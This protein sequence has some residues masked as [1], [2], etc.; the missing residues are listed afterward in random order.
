MSTGLRCPLCG[1]WYAEVQPSV[2][3]FF[4]AGEV[5]G[6]M[7]QTGPNPDQCSPSHPCPGILVPD[8]SELDA[9]FDGLL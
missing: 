3:S 5:C 2:I 6:N 7:A 4:E 1:S 8:N 9:K